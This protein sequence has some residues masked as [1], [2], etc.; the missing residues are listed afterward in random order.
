M[1]F[2]GHAWWA[3]CALGLAAC[4][5]SELVPLA[6]VDARANDSVVDSGASDLGVE[7][8]TMVPDVNAG[9]G[10]C[11][12]ERW[13][14]GPIVTY[15]T[16]FFSGDENGGPAL[17]A[18]DFDGDGTLDLIAFFLTPPAGALWSNRGDGTFA[19]RT[20]FATDSPVY[21]SAV[22]D[23]NGDGLAD[24]ALGFASSRQVVEV[25]TNRGDGTFAITSTL[26][27]MDGAWEI[28]VADLN[29]DGAPDLAMTDGFEYLEIALNRGDGTFAGT[30]RY[31]NYLVETFAVG[32]VNHDGALDIVGTSAP[33]ESPTVGV[34]LNKGDGTF[35]AAIPY[36]GICNDTGPIAL[37]DFN[38]D[39]WLDVVR[40]CW[41]GDDDVAVRLNN[42]DGT[43]G[44]ETSYGVGPWPW[45]VAVGRFLTT[46]GPLDVAA[47]PALGAAYGGTG[48][49]VLP[50]NGD[51]TFGNALGAGSPVSNVL[52]AGD[53][54]G[55]G[56]PDIAF[57][58]GN[59]F[60]VLFFVCE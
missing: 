17:A 46:H 23:F 52:V 38:G 13:R 45:P 39:G 35:G 11:A 25:F 24:F 26:T 50:G 9:D 3:A 1:T 37:G 56:H 49:S 48:V 60:G 16:P 43:F 19:L 30:V 36:P 18:G 14:F 21:A 41:Q 34:L 57:A 28:A 54:N 27:P 59:A 44:S 5:R 15:A 10:A 55:D 40:S 29:G 20:K 7:P 22:G 47:A 32:D 6:D 33:F 12:S 4:G 8:E 2:E 53:F 31:D 58:A 51:G 42:G